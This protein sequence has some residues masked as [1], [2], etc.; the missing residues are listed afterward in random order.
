MNTENKTK[1]RPGRK[2]LPDAEKV[3]PILTYHKRSKVDAAGGAEKVREL[4]VN[5]LNKK[6]G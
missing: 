5:F 2:A 3:I 6:L 1:S 4:V